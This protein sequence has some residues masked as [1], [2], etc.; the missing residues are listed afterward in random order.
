MPLIHIIIPIQTLKLLRLDKVLCDH[1]FFYEE[2]PP[3]NSCSF[4][5]PACRG[6]TVWDSSAFST[7]GDQES[8]RL[9]I[10]ISLANKKPIEI[11]AT[12]TVYSLHVTFL[13]QRSE[14]CPL[15][16]FSSLFH[17]S[18]DMF[19]SPKFCLFTLSVDLQTVLKVP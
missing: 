10:S 19:R 16:S 13:I 7:T 5:E 8:D 18:C 11:S 4:E 3:N 9:T 15:I 6:P 1:C 12:E 14:C 17:K 2:A